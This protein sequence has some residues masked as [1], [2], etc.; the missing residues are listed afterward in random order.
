MKALLTHQGLAEA[1]LEDVN[2]DRNHTLTKKIRT[3][4]KLHCAIILCLGD[5]VLK[6]VS[7]EKLAPEVW[8]KLENLY[9]TKSLRNHLYFKR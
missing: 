5:R 7:Q 6:E 2:M 9:M 8:K 4:E 1:L 3:N